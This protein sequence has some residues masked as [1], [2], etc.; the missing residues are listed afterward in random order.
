MN[1]N[2]LKNIIWYHTKKDLY[3]FWRTLTS[4]S[5]IP[6]YS[7]LASLMYK[8]DI[9]FCLDKSAV[10]SLNLSWKIFV[11]LSLSPVPIEMLVNIE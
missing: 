7:E 10:N 1:T 4:S 5:T 2:F 6:I 8:K 9:G 11:D 3:L